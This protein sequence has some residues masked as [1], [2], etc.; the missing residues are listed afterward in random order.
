[1]IR[2]RPFKPIADLMSSVSPTGDAKLIDR[3]SAKTLASIGFVLITA[4]FL[5]AMELINIRFLLLTYSALPTFDGWWNVTPG[6]LKSQFFTHWNEHR[7]IVPR[8]F[9][10][11]D[12]VF[13]SGR[14]VFTIASTHTLFA[15]IGILFGVLAGRLL[16]NKFAG[17]GFTF[18]F[19]GLFLSL[20]Q[21]AV[22]QWGFAITWPAVYLFAFL[23]YLCVFP[24]LGRPRLVLSF[25]F[26]LAASFSMAN[27]S[28]CFVP[29]CLIAAV[30]R[31]YRTFTFALVGTLVL[32]AIQMIGLRP[33]SLPPL[34]GLGD[35]AHL[36]GYVF[37]F[38]GAPLA[39]VLNF[40]LGLGVDY[41]VS[42]LLLSQAIGLI[43]L[44]IFLGTL[45]GVWRHPDPCNAKLCLCAIGIFVILSALITAWGRWWLPAISSRYGGPA[46]FF[47]ASTF[48]LCLKFVGVEA[49]ATR[50]VVVFLICTIPL[51]VFF[52]TFQVH[53]A[54]RE[55]EAANNRKLA[56]SALLTRTSDPVALVSVWAIPALVDEVYAARLAIFSDPWV[57][58]LGKEIPVYRQAPD[59]CTGALEGF[60]SLP[61]ANAQD[62]LLSFLPELKTI[63]PANENAR[64]VSG[65]ADFPGHSLTTAKIV[66]VNRHN[67]VSGYAF[68]G[69]ERRD[70][71]L[72]YPEVL[73]NYSGWYGHIDDVRLAPF[74]AYLLLNDGSMLC[75]LAT[76]MR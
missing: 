16:N 17:I 57:D 74:K 53:V 62:P 56:A 51:L 42:K 29:I 7:I 22:L 69:W 2:K 10:L 11:A 9:F 54:E 13:F 23:A 63:P 45:V 43:L 4:L 39:S 25:S 40:H 14:Q 1:M 6:Q 47:T 75:A 67:I 5:G 31:N 64:R 66:I 59:R 24:V 18:L 46:L 76:L 48:L 70:I 52:L 8:L 19:S 65:W 38:I 41:H 26:A 12:A 44:L 37:A 30:Q 49:K 3:L 35:I 27:G 72:T 71:R 60:H 15:M 61:A 68:T 73:S 58:W 55:R 36:A 32:I 34:Q 20:Y 33:Q 28:I 50:S 21:F